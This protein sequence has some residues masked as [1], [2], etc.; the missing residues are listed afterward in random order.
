[1]RLFYPLP[2]YIDNGYFKIYVCSWILE[3]AIFAI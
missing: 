2:F 3:P 1:L